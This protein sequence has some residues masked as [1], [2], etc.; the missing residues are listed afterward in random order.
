[1]E[2]EV[3]RQWRMVGKPG[4]ESSITGHCRQAVAAGMGSGDG[5]SEGNGVSHRGWDTR[6]IRV[7]VSVMSSAGHLRTDDRQQTTDNTHTHTH[8]MLPLSGR[9]RL[10]TNGTK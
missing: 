6:E 2:D 5:A 8:R 9:C 1:M 7:R 4:R 3:I 10:F